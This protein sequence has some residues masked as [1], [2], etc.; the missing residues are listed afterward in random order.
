MRKNITLLGVLLCMS[1][2]SWGQKASVKLEISPKQ[3]PTRATGMIVRY[4]EEAKYEM[5]KKQQ[6]KVKWDSVGTLSKPILLTDRNAKVACVYE[7]KNLKENTGYVFQIYL[8]NKE[9]KGELFGDVVVDTGG[10]DFVT[11]EMTDMPIISMFPSEPRKKV[12]SN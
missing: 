5:A 12:K 8:V 7:V 2:L 4:C 9:E 3:V 11:G 1:T 6:K 10:I